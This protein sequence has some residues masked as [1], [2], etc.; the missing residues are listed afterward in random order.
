MKKRVIIVIV[1]I[2][3]P[4]LV[5]AETEDRR[6]LT[7]HVFVPSAVVT[8]P[9]MTRDYTMFIQGGY[10]SGSVNGTDIKYMATSF[11]F[12]TDQPIGR[13]VSLGFGFSAGAGTGVNETSALLFGASGNLSVAGNVK[14][15]A[16]QNRYFSISPFAQ[17][18]WGM[19][20]MIQPAV[21][22]NS[23][24]VSDLLG[25]N[26]AIE[27]SSG[28]SMA[29]GFF[30]YMGM[31]L[32]A[33]YDFLHEDGN[34][35]SVDFATALSAGAPPIGV[36]VGYKL[37]HDFTNST[38]GHTIDAGVFYMSGHHFSIGTLFQVE[39]LGEFSIKVYSAEFGMVFYQ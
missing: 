1:A 4:V 12:V 27:V 26:Q 29:V 13:I 32:S 36:T 3:C 39:F 14:I 24:N 34:S 5:F 25:K 22:I 17:V 16:F 20:Y 6:V 31:A 15:N 11:N 8:Q 19:R 7:S 10:A 33:S 9:F 23:G 21:A 38:N 2:L 37:S 18:G 28:L 30:K 35:H